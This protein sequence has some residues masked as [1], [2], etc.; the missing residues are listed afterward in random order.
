MKLLLI[1]DSDSQIL[2]CEALCRFSSDLNLDITINAVP[3]EGTPPA[4][5]Q[6]AAALGRL[7]QLTVAQIYTHK[8]LSTFDAIGVY[9]TGSKIAEFKSTLDLMP[10][11]KRRPL[12]F[13][14]FNGV[15]LEKFIEGVTWRLGYDVICLSGPRDLEALRR[16]TAKTPFEAQKTALTGLC[17]NYPGSL[18]PY[19]KRKRSLVFSEQVVM[20]R[21]GPNRALMLKILSDLA[22]RSPNWEIIVK[23]RI[24]P[25]ESTF[26]KFNNHIQ[27]TLSSSIGRI[28]D[29][30][31]L[32]YRPLPDLLSQAR[33]MATVSSTAFFD[34]LDFGCRPIVMADFGINPRNGSHVF[35]GSGVWTKLN[36]I[37]TL[38]QLDAENQRPAP[39]WLRWMGYEPSFRPDNLIAALEEA[40]PSPEGTTNVV[41]GYLTN[42][43]VTFM[44]LR[45]N[46]ESA[47]VANKLNEAASFL[48]LACQ[49]RPTH[50]NVARRL[51][52]VT[53]RNSL[54]RSLLLFVTRT[55]IR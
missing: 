10:N 8:E 44:Q 54:L 11:L 7:W 33:M 31:R 22:K 52:A 30:F 3:R 34:A 53:C 19:K 41:P 12:L 2:A 45:L 9:L 24:A 17:R 18:T 50:R 28:P 37:D 23:P 15:V 35:A 51:A 55:K 6:R 16:I 5:L 32:D 40:E 25:E 14:G 38:D 46:A 43:G 29:N 36:A 49:M 4:I 27:E 21:R 39:E 13:C 26:H 1:G 47:I 48:R 20:P 42:S